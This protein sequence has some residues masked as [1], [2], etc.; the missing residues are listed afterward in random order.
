MPPV[1]QSTASR[2]ENEGRPAWQSAASYAAR[3][4]RH[5]LRKDNATPYVAHVV[6]VAMTVRDVFGCNDPIV[7]CAAFLHDTIEDTGADYDDIE[8]NFGPP[9]AVTVAAMTKNMALPESQRE[10]AYDQQLARA[11]WRARLV[12]L[13][14]CFDNLSDMYDHSAEGVRWVLD[15][16]E[17]AI[18]LAENGGDT[19][20]HHESRAAV[21][22]LRS[23]M[24]DVRAGT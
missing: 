8:A 17:R 18:A 1:E 19:R 22:S 15:K 13:A 3:A 24:N 11:D 10:P 12:K 4:H 2:S 14:D 5:Q 7:I 16:C 6:R 9:V 20:T 21:S 23:L